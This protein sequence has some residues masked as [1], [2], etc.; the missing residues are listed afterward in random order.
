MTL[1]HQLHNRRRLL[2]TSA[3]GFGQLAAQRVLQG[4]A[5]AYY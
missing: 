3:I 1:I 2:K 4:H 5:G